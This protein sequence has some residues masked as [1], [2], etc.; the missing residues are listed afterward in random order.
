MAPSSPS[1]GDNDVDSGRPRPVKDRRPDIPGA[2]Q[3]FILLWS[4]WLKVVSDPPGSQCASGEG[5]REAVTHDGAGSSWTSGPLSLPPAPLVG[6]SLRKGAGSEVGWASPDP[7]FS[8]TGGGK[9]HHWGA[10]G[11][12]VPTLPH[13]PPIWEQGLPEG[14]CSRQ[15]P[16]VAHG[17][18]PTTHAHLPVPFMWDWGH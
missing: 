9:G 16:R 5:C 18:L 1:S 2:V 12:A 10:A 13:L 15:L 11:G 7:C 6:H 3:S 4:C 8:V 14:P 17:A